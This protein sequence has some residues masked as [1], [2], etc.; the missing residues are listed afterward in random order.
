MLSPDPVRRELIE[1]D[2]K[3][4]YV[5]FGTT[6]VRN[7]LKDFCFEGNISDVDDKVTKV[8]LLG[9][10]DLRNTFQATT[11]KNPQ[12]LE[13]HL[14]D[15][16]PSVLARNIIILKIVSASDFNPDNDEDFGFLWDVWYNMDW[17]EETRK[18]FLSVVKE[19]TNEKLP[20]NV[21]I[22]N[23]SHLEEL[24][25]L[26]SNWHSVSSKNKN[27]SVSLLRKVWGQRNQCLLDLM[28]FMY[29]G[30]LQEKAR[31]SNADLFTASLK[32]LAKQFQSREGFIGLAPSV[33]KKINNEVLE[34]YRNG[35]TRRQNDEKPV[36]VNPTLLNP[37]THDWKIFCFFTPFD[38]YMPMEKGELITSV[39]QIM[40]HS[41]SEILKRLVSSYRSRI[42]TVKIVFHLEEAIKHCYSDANKFDVIDC[43][44]FVSRVGLAN[45]VVA[46]CQKLSD[47]PNAVFYT[48]I[49]TDD[50]HSA[51]N[52][53]ET[54]LCA[55][56]SMIPTIY[57]LRLADHVEL[58]DSAVDYLRCNALRRRYPVILCWQKVPN[59]QNIK[60]VPSPDLNRCLTKLAKLCHQTTLPNP[61]SMVKKCRGGEIYYT[62]LT[63]NYILD[64]MIKRLG[65]DCWLPD[66][67]DIAP[68]FRL[69]RRV[70]EDWKNGKEMKKFSAGVHKVKSAANK[71]RTPKVRLV[72]VARDSDVQYID[73]FELEFNHTSKGVAV[74]MVSFLLPS[75]HTFDGTYDAIVVNAFNGM[76]LLVLDP[77]ESMRVEEYLVPYPI[78]QS[79]SQL[80]LDPKGKMYMKVESCIESEE[81]YTL[82]IAIECDGNVS[83]LK[84][85]TNEQAP[86][87]SCHDVTV[88]LTQPSKIQP[89]S[90]TFPFPILAKNVQATLHPKSRHVDL[91][92]KKSLLE[93]WPCE[94]HSKKSKWIIG[95]LVPWKNKPVNSEDGFKNLED[96]LS[97]QFVSKEMSYAHFRDSKRSALDNLRLK[98]GV[99]MTSDIEFVSYGRNDDRYL[100]KLHRPLL[101]SPTGT[102]ILLITALNGIFSRKLG[103]NVFTINQTVP[104]EK[105]TEQRKIVEKVFPLGT[106]KDIKRIMDAETEEEFQLFRFLLRLN[107]TRIVP[108]KCQKK[109][110][111]LGGSSHWLATFL[112]PLYQDSVL[113]ESNKDE[114]ADEKCCAAC[115]KIPEKLKF[116]SRCR[117]TVYC[118]VECQHS[119]WPMHKLICKK[120]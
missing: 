50:H 105:E 4:E 32:E 52:I 13:I 53:V 93:P 106:P 10:D 54:S 95:D 84:I 104:K 97:S 7:V 55:P 1:S 71:E 108:N 88:S 41:C 12:N 19:L 82:R 99:L 22:P 77:F 33:K 98:L 94:F 21:S 85:S 6:R 61:V 39:E 96:H 43:S 119:H 29:P 80:P 58:R 67:L 68:Q 81:Q 115:K 38:G 83:G 120:L 76:S 42:P 15:L 56:L 24:K 78:G 75:D 69:A 40:T 17:S 44:D 35:I 73:N 30:H 100:L 31:L 59:F 110:I 72:L 74:K 20:D 51:N 36:C 14:N 45:L 116:C 65:H 23:K 102:P 63:F 91:L 25:S 8:L 5:P 28:V 57:G 9:C 92:L 109:N 16:S 114:P 26:W 27:D 86:C 11:S 79:K 37:K 87:E 113:T 46:C 48:E 103:Q 47:N 90:L 2:C 117:S 64:S 89:L 66:L 107:S 62:P 3:T 60:L 34:C 112:S 18:R 101:T 118:S 49:M 111:P 70:M